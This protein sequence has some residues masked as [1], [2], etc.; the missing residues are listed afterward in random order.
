MPDKS[1]SKS[2]P[3][4]AKRR[5]EILHDIGIDGNYQPSAAQNWERFTG[6]GWKPSRGPVYDSDKGPFPEVLLRGIDDA[7]RTGLRP[8]NPDEED[9]PVQCNAEWHFARFS[10]EGSKIAPLIY[11]M[12]MRVAGDGGTWSLSAQKIAA[13]LNVEKDD[14][15]YAAIDLLVAAGFF[16]VIEEMLGRPT[17][18]RPI[19]HRQWAAKHSGFCTVKHEFPFQ[20]ETVVAALGRKLH[21]ILGGETFFTGVLIGLRKT[22][23]TPDEICGYARQFLELDKGHGGGKERRKRFG[24]YLREQAVSLGRAPL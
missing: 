22:G 16:E 8:T 7:R 4:P 18:Y 2:K 17:K 14:Y 21:G 3:L 6:D 19:G 11:G 13:F 24:V 9:S 1:K 15:V 20:D 23:L 5:A 10:G 12:A